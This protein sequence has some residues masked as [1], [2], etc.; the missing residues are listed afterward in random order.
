MSLYPELQRLDE[1]RNALN[2]RIS[3][4]MHAQFVGRRVRVNHYHGSFTGVVRQVGWHEFSV[5]VV[6]DATG[7]ASQRWP[8]LMSNGRPDVEL[9]DGGGDD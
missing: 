9:I 5:V 4:A 6:N 3:E 1:E 2:A 8:L 7:K